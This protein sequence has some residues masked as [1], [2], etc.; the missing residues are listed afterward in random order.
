MS[1]VQREYERIADAMRLPQTDD[2]YCQ[3]YSAQQA[4]AWASDPESYAAP[5]DTISNGKVQ[6]LTQDTPAG[7]EDCSDVVRRSVS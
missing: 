3:L 1:F 6:P 5:S 4:L 7:S 2:R